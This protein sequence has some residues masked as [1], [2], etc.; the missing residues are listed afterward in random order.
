MKDFGV[1]GKGSTG[2]AHY[3]QDFDR[4]H[5]GGSGGPGRPGGSGGGGWIGCLV[6][7]VELPAAIGV[8]A[9][10]AWLFNQLG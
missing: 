3:K 2:Y 4:I 8:L 6:L 5:G 1:Y 9:G 7:L 10:M